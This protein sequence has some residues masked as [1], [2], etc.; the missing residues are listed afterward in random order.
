LTSPTSPFY[1]R[2]VTVA[3]ITRADFTDDR[4]RDEI[5]SGRL[6][7]GSRIPVERLAEE[8]GVSPTPV[9]ESMRRLA[10]EGLVTLLPQRGGRVTTID[11]EAAGEL[12]AVR[13]LLEPVAIRQSIEVAVGDA[14]WLAE[15][16]SSFRRLATSDQTGRID[17]HADFHRAVMS[18]CPNGTL[19]STIDGLMMRSRLFQ[20]LA[21]LSRRRGEPGHEHRRLFDAARAGD[22]DGAVAVQTEHLSSTLASLRS[23]ADGAGVTIE[24]NRR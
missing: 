21:H 18:R 13:I 22:A 4:L 5:L 7:P 6:G 9:R 24:N 20:A 3:P 12:Y 23:L 14:T 2:R 19:L 15:L 1:V 16:D 17:A 11:V 8:W 10:G